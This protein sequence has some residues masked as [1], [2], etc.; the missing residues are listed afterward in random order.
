MHDAARSGPI[1]SSDSDAGRWLDA[2]GMSGDLF[3][4]SEPFSGTW[5][6][7]L[8]SRGAVVSAA[9]AGAPHRR[10]RVF[11]VAWPAADAQDWGQQPQLP[12]GADGSELGQAWQDAG[13]VGERP[14]PGAGAGDSAGR[15]P[16]R[17]AADPERDG[18]QRR[19]TEDPGGADVAGAGSRAEAA[20]RGPAAADAYGQD[21]GP[22][23]GGGGAAA[24]AGPGDGPERRA[25]PDLPSV[26]ALL[27]TPTAQLATNGGSQHPDKRREGGTGRRWPTRWSR[28]AADTRGEGTIGGTP[29]AGGGLRLLP[30]PTARLG[31]IR[32]GGRTR[33]GT[34]DPSR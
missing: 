32:A 7:L 34:R 9:D 30:T 27:K 12:G 31:T 3:G 25:S 2:N 11:I 19:A 28:A 14:G 15:D 4:Q 20:G 8:R 29:A 6:T 22:Q 23:R 5:P 1:A 24:S 21:A 33:P 10:E 17:T 13:R 16:A 26:V 18:R